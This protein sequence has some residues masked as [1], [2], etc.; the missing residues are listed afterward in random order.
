MGRDH[1]HFFEHEGL[2]I[3]LKQI[4]WFGLHQEDHAERQF[5]IRPFTRGSIDNL[6]LPNPCLILVG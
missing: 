4:L 5:P 1:R 6:A 3:H 2:A